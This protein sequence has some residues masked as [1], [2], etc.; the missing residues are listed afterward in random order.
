MELNNSN[1]NI[2]LG[3]E[4]EFFLVDPESRD[5]IAD[6][7]PAIFEASK[8]ASGP[9]TVVHEFLRSQ[10]ETNTRV[11]ANFSDLRE[12]LNETRRL[13]IDA[14][15][16]HG[17]A[18]IAASTHPFA[19]WRVQLPTPQ[20]RY[21]R[22]A[23]T[24]Q[25]RR[26]FLVNGM[27]IHAGFGDPESRIRVMTALRRHLP[28]LNALSASSPF[29][30]GRETGFKSYRLNLLNVVPRFGL[31]PAFFSRRDFDDL[32]KAYQSLKFINDG[33]EFWWDLRPSSKY[34]TI[35]LRICD[36]C[37]R[38]DDALAVAAV[39]ASLIRKLLRQNAE[40]TL[41]PE[42]P[43]DI[44]AENRWLAS[45]YGILAFL[46]DPAIG[47]RID[48]NDQLTALV[49]DL[50]EDAQAL[51]CEAELRHSLTIIREGAGADLQL[52]HFRLRRLEGDSTEQAL[53]A[54]TDLAIQETMD[55]S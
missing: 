53:R 22:F 10:I 27:H 2:T 19:D 11:C 20:D 8:R 7:D 6:P 3:V 24:Y 18:V 38:L 13:I 50:G 49:Y 31:P 43:S 44:I 1:L 9:H 5:L 16:Q 23:I 12:A 33:S 17:V 34:P 14:A 35:E 42:P 37:T 36:V 52:D 45:R 40:G 29:S 32:L 21:Q 4:E 28:L 48:I 15:R 39:Y 46:G 55:G 25:E 30:A 51:G 26:S 41:P 54:V 47:Q